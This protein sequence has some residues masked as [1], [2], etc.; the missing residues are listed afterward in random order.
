MCIKRT[1]SMC[2]FK[3]RSSE[4]RKSTDVPAIIN[5]FDRFSTHMF[6]EEVGAIRPRTKLQKCTESGRRLGY[7]SNILPLHAQHFCAFVK[8]L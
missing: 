3:D 8:R 2:H 7:N 1:F 6:M 5:D 4:F